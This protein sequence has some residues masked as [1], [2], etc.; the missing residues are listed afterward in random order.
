MNPGQHYRLFYVALHWIS[1]L[2]VFGTF[3]I[4]LLSL[5]NTPNNPEK[6]FPLTVHLALGVLVLALTIARLIVRTLM[7]HPVT[8]LAKISPRAAMLDKMSVYVQPMLY[9]FTFL[10]AAT[11]IAIALPAGLLNGS[12][13]QTTLPPDFYVYPARTW[14]GA[15]SLALMLL[16]GLHLLAFFYHQGLRGENFI[17]RMWFAP[18]S[19]HNKD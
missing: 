12:L 5:A 18:K 3:L 2:L 1:A 7:G 6:L 11:G 15:I 9:L 10:M 8:R 17:G 16:I 19:K 14:H 13:W 4:G